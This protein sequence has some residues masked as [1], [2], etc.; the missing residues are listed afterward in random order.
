L[1]VLI[2]A[3]IMKPMKILVTG[4]AGYI[5]SVTAAMLV[6]AG[7]AVTVVDDL[8]RGHRDAVIEGARWVQ[9]DF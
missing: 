5:G 6:E 7:H 3:F 9:A 4:G 2:G 8:S 1:A